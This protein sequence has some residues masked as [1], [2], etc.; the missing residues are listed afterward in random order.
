MSAS[1][2]YSK[3][4]TPLFFLNLCRHEIG[5]TGCILPTQ[6]PHKPVQKAREISL[7]KSSPRYYFI[8]TPCFY[9][10]F[11]GFRRFAVTDLAQV[12]VEHFTD[13]GFEPKP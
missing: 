1:I 8:E 13:L 6:N 9:K 11:R 2:I 3:Q 4:R 7:I 5:T 10:G 12:F